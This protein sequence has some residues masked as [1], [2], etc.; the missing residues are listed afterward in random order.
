MKKPYLAKWICGPGRA[1]RGLA[2][3]WLLHAAATRAAR[4][5]A[6]AD[7]AKDD[8]NDDEEEEVFE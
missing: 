5:V 8:E 7:E 2:G 1:R 4:V 3:N 6:A